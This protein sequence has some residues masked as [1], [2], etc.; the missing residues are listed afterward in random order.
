MP[1]V[2]FPYDT[3]ESKYV[4]SLVGTRMI[5]YNFSPTSVEFVFYCLDDFKPSTLTH[6]PAHKSVTVPKGSFIALECGITKTNTI[7]QDTQYSNV[8]IIGWN[9]VTAKMCPASEY[10]QL[11]M[12]RSPK[13]SNTNTNNE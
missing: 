10:Q 5:I 1:G 9:Y 2:L 4:R 13:Y 3:E 12:S 6:V 8:E 11:T 7:T